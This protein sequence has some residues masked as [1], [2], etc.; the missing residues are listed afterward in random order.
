[1][2]REGA[3]VLDAREDGDVGGCD[4]CAALLALVAS[5]ARAFWRVCTRSKRY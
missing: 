1:M 4:N 5:C 2:R 3:R